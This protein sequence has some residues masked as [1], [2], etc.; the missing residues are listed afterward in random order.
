MPSNPH[1]GAFKGMKFNRTQQLHLERLRLNAAYLDREDISDYDIKHLI[2]VAWDT[3]EQDVD[4]NEKKVRLTLMLDESVAK[5]FRAMGR[6]YQ[7]RINRILGTFVQ[8]R[9]AQVTMENAR[10]EQEIEKF[11]AAFKRGEV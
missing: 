11:N 7:A 2:P 3:L 6:G 1:R 4:V 8:M 10:V 5:F 9:M